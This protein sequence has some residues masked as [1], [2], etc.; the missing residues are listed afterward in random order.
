MKFEVTSPGL[1]D[2]GGVASPR[3]RFTLERGAFAGQ[4]FTAVLG[5]C[6]SPCCHCE[7]V[8]FECQPDPGACIAE[9][10]A[11]AS[12]VPVRFD[13]DVFRQ[14]VN[15]AVE[16]SRDAVAL[17]RAAAAELEADDWEALGKLFL[18]AKR[19][20][21]E[22]MNL[23]ALNASFPPDVMAGDGPMVGYAEV[24]PW[25]EPFELTLEGSPCVV[26]DHYCAQPGCDCAE[27]ALECFHVPAERFPP[28][29]R[30]KAGVFLRHNHASGQTTVVEAKRGSPA[31]EKWIE[32]LRDAHPGFERTLQERHRQ[33]KRLGERLLPKTARRSNPAVSHLRDEELEEPVTAPSAPG[34]TQA[35]KVGRNQPCPCGSGRKYKR[36]CGG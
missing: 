29:R 26:F 28:G 25:A 2:A 33:L 8:S 17:G 14:A 1:A 15:V 35:P 16:S 7:A 12:S 24:F 10:G 34:A 31:P 11:P 23:D 30:L 27:A 3:A 21:M 36:C 9:I 32:A 6:P 20:Q 5:V 19:R 18:A 4:A 13:L 22:T